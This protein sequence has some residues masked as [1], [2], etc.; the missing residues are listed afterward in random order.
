MVKR[1]VKSSRVRCCF[2]YY[3]ASLAGVW[4]S[5][6][7][8]KPEL[9]LQ[10]L[11]SLGGAWRFTWARDE[12]EKS[13]IVRFLFISWFSNNA[14]LRGWLCL[15]PL[16]VPVFC[17]CVTFE[18][19]SNHYSIQVVTIKLHWQSIGFRS[20]CYW[21][22]VVELS[23]KNRILT[24]TEAFKETVY[25]DAVY[26]RRYIYIYISETSTAQVD[27]VLETLILVFK[28]EDN[29]IRYTLNYI[30]KTCFKK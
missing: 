5:S 24:F 6:D 7:D 29:K 12:Q 1:F 28:W 9:L 10:A 11:S 26:L 4:K 21:Q 22:I 17:F 25:F 13:A 18:Q 30:R 15:L 19:L 16:T 20:Q 27:I 14:F 3:W 23:T 2:D 8:V